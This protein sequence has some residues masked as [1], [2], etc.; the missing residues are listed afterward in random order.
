MPNFDG[1]GPQGQGPL[2]GRKRGECQ[3]ND[4]AGPGQGRGCPRMM[5]RGGGCGRGRGGRMGQGPQSGN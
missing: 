3:S 4:L 1:T 2:T 5:N